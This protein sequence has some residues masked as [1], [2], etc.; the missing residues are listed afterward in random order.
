M[1]VK[2]TLSEYGVCRVPI[3]GEK[4]PPPEHETVTK[5]REYECTAFNVS[6]S[7]ALCLYRNGDG[8]LFAAFREWVRVEEIE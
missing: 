6:I 7:G 5:E 4:Q 3:P 2:V 8:R 1:K